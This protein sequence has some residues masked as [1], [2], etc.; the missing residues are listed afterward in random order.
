MRASRLLS[1]LL[2][3]QSHGRLTAAELAQRLE[4]SVRTI[5]RD[6]ESLHTAGIPL[7]GEAGHAGGYRLVDGWRTR[8]TGLTAE[9]ADRLLFAGLPGPAAELGY[10]S[11]V[12]TVQLKLRAALPPPLADRA[13]QLQ[14]RFHLDTPS[15]YSDG[16]PS[17][18]LAPTADAVWRQHRIR[19]R[20]RSW[21]GEVPRILEPYGL[22][23]KGG[24]WYVVAARPERAEPAT[25]RVNQILELTALDEPFDRPAEFDL[26]AWW[27]A[28]VVEFRARL[29]RD[30]AIIRLSAQGRDRLREVGSDAVVAA[31]DAS[32]GP[33]DEVGWVR[34]V[35]PIESLTHAH[36]DFLRLGAE[37]EVLSPAE[38]RDRL[39]DTAAALA[40]LYA[41][42]HQPAGTPAPAAGAEPRVGP[43]VAP[44]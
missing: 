24:R 29:H 30:E 15:W 39:A 35:V 2:L 3:L 34:A 38:L 33:P 41:P 19:V 21:R 13:A 1:I 36:G 6:V 43:R 10:E 28:H 32:A 22:V 14:Q 25:Y 26:P 20:Y 12:A 7:Y 8:L 9:E 4:V 16:D 18:H 40:A 44:S 37:V 31:V 11:V 17:P 5:Y 27:R 42:P 23:L